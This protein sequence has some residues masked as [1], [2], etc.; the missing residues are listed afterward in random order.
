MRQCHFLPQLW[1]VTLL[2]APLLAV[3]YVDSHAGLSLSLL[4]PFAKAPLTSLHSAGGWLAEA[5]RAGRAGG[6]RDAR[7]ACHPRRASLAIAA[8]PPVAGRTRVT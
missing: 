3:V 1:L 5:R 6:A 7:D 4:W 2:W 8:V